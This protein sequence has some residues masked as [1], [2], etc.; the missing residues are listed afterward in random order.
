MRLRIPVLFHV[1]RALLQYWGLSLLNAAGLA[2]GF[3][4]AI[5]IALYIRD[6]LS[7]D[8]FVPG[9]D[10]VLM[11]TSVYSA[12]DSPVVSNDKSPAGVAAWLRGNAPAVEAAAR[13][14]PGE[15]PMRSP[16]FQAVEP[17]YWADPNLFDLL[18][19]KAVAGDLKAALAKPFTAVVTQKVAQRYF[20]RDDVVGQTLF[21][22]GDSPVTITAVLADLPANN[23]LGREIFLSGP[24]NYGM[25]AVL[26]RN[27]GWQWAS[28]YTFVRLRP[29][30]RLDGHT[31]QHIV[32][33]HWANTFNLPTGFRLSPLSDL[34]FQ[35]EADSQIA[36]RGHRDTVIA[37]AGVAGLILVLAAVNFAG[38]MSAQ[39][40]ERRAEMSIRRSLGAQRH[41]LFFQLFMETTVIS[42]LSVVAGLALVERVLP[43][44]NPVLGLQLSLWTSP[45]FA[46]GCAAVAALTGI[47]G[48]IY[49]SLVLSSVPASPAR[50]AGE[51]SRGAYLGRVGWIAVQ[52]SLLI[53]ILVAAQTVYR[54]WL[55]V[56]GPALNFDAARVIQIDV[57]ANSGLED[58][59]RQHILTLSGV[60]DAAYSRFVPEERDTRPGWAMSPSGRRIQFN[61][62]TVDTH[63]FHMFGV[64]LLAGRNFS[65][66]YNAN[67]A[68]DEIIL[69]RATAR[70]LGYRTP[71][72]AVGRVLDYEGDHTH[73]RATIIGVV[74]DMRLDTAREPLRPTIFDNQAYFFTR[75]NVKL[76][77]GSEDSTLAAIDE[78]WKHDY[79]KVNPITRR[80]Y[81]DYL[82]GL[83]HDMI[84][85]W[86]AFGLLSVV[87]AC[88]STLGLIGLSVYLART[89]AREIAI[90]N[91]LGARLWDIFLLRIEPFVKPLLI[92]NAVAGVT[93]WALM[94]WWLRSFSAHVGLD[95]LS[96]AGAG[97]L[98]VLIAIVTLL[99]HAA[100]TSPARSSQ[101]LRID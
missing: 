92:A 62:E 32:A 35:P 70:A 31:V 87:G 42:A 18:R 71:A 28:S 23:S 56:T 95:P 101:P 86:W 55:F 63:F 85:Q 58:S 41:H 22:N 49:P 3:A 69:S 30:T 65:G 44:V 10:K 1:G 13:L 15:W 21:I 8:R 57:F 2:I 64:R 48:G 47:A 73:L 51:T 79:P 50:E 75:L 20:G 72:A 37:M 43:L 36:P 74:D 38:L 45:P 14:V 6:E 99:V 88:I 93:A 76:R 54:Q 4:A 68:P 52:F 91:A 9:A 80:F 61:R 24:S 25:L 5:I 60:E 26:D 7:F 97:A 19:L 39:I 89:R 84:Q 96:F 66:V 81:A 17:Y 11:V 77:P 90:R 53:T 83:Y 59:F 82:G 46:A 94:S 27:P 100:S 34:H 67:H 33:Q 40:D 12:P 29:G 78:T 98:T 16:R